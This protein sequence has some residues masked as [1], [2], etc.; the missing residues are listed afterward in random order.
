[1]IC[2]SFA[3]DNGHVVL[4]TS[5][6]LLTI[7][8]Q[9]I[10]KKR[11]EAE[12]S[13]GQRRLPPEEYRNTFMRPYRIEDRKPVLISRKLRDT[14]ERFACKIGGNR[15]SLLGLLENTVRHH[16]RFYTG[17]FEF[18]KKLQ[19]LIS[20]QLKKHFGEISFS[21]ALKM[22]TFIFGGS[23]VIFRA[24]RKPRSTSGVA[25]AIRSQ[26]SQIAGHIITVK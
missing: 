16:I 5:T 10:M 17:D 20:I 26:R 8:N 7:Q 18:C 15:M 13:G 1:M 3:A 22:E 19:V 9:R 4:A 24:S 25:E 23:E 12:A 11:Q 21:G 14:L 2:V 6:S